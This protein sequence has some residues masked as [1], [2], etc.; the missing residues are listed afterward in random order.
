MFAKD[1]SSSLFDVHQIKNSFQ[2]KEAGRFCFIDKLVNQ[3]FTLLIKKCYKFDIAI[4][5]K[6]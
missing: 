4:Y 1:N 3:T 5:G 2:S 6:K